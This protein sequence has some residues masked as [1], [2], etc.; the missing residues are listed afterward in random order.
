MTCM[1]NVW[2]RI[3]NFVIDGLGHSFQPPSVG[4]SLTLHVLG[5]TYPILYQDAAVHGSSALLQAVSFYRCDANP[6]W[7]KPCAFGNI[8][9]CIVSLYRHACVLPFH[10]YVVVL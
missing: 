5:F 7:I 2:R 9:A 8:C 10:C 1:K 4:P 6:D 3:W